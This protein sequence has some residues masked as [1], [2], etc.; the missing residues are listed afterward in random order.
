M[1]RLAK[2][3]SLVLCLFC[4][5]SARAQSDLFPFVVP[6]DGAPS[7]AAD[8]SVLLH[9]PAG[10][11]G[12]VR[13]GADGHFYVGAQRIRFWGVNMTAGSCFQHKQNAP[14]VALRLAKAGVNIVRFHHMDAPWANPSL[15]NYSTGGSRQLNLQALD[16]LDY[17]FAQLKQVGIYTNINL[18]VHRRFS[19]RD[20]LPAEIDSV[21]DMKD[22]HVIGF[23]YQPMIELQKEYARQLLTHRNPYTGLTYA[24]DPAVAFVEINNENGLI[25]GFLGSVLDRIPAVFQQ[26]LQR[27][28][29]E[30]L[31]AK[32]GNSTNLRQAWGERS[33]PLGPEM[34]TNGNYTNGTTGWYLEQHAGAQASATV[35]TDAP[36]GY[37]RSVRIQVTRA[38]SQGWHIQWGQPGLRVVGNGIYTL[39]FWA[40]A[41][42]N[43]NFTVAIAMAHEPWSGLT[44]WTPVSLTTTWRRYEFTFVVRQDDDNA[45]VLF[46]DMGLNTGSYWITGV[47]LRR[48]GTVRVIPVDQSLEARNIASVLRS[49]WWNTPE[50]IQ[51]DWLRFLRDTEERYWNGLYR[52]LK[53]DLGVRALVTGTII[54]CALPSTMAQTDLIDTHSYWQHPE[55][56]GGDWDP[57][58]WFI[59]NIPMVNYR[60]NTF[61]GLAPKRVWGKPFTLSEYNHPAPNTYTSEGLILLAAYALLQDWDAVYFY[62]YAHRRDELDARRITGFFD[63]DQH[64][65]Q[66]MSLVAAAAMFLR[67]DVAP[68]QQLVG[69]TLSREQEIEHL[70][71][72]WAWRLV[73]GEHVGLRGLIALK[74]RVAVALEGQTLPISTLRPD[75]VDTSG[76]VLVSDTG[77]LRWDWSVPGRGVFTVASPRT[78]AVVGFGAGRRFDLGDG[79]VVEPGN[80]RQNGFSAITLTVKQGVLSSQVTQHTQLLITATGYVQNTDWGWEE[81]GDNRVTV[82]D[83]WGRAP[84]LVEGISARIT[85]PMPASVVQVYALDGRGGRT[86]RVPVGRTADGKAVVEIGPQYGTL[87]YE[88]VASARRPITRE[89]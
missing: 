42:T 32:Y 38:G 39:S 40:K 22:Q 64:P 83:N 86:V 43:R 72:S 25:Q 82:R 28:W 65:T 60:D 57:R 80:T 27:Q 53:Q 2:I 81:L 3:L 54:G 12:P 21:T 19:S 37:S 59:R 63:I 41:S 62:T 30:W 15:I 24:Q 36:S 16:N 66:W 35:V 46:T 23:F 48:G 77:Q 73:D 6:W 7:G 33:E 51:K 20:G 69:V 79:V 56:P 50:P 18:L 52:Y 84:S 49:N 5:Q 89:R 29:N 45:R 70:R 55:F 68:A 34:L 74:H 14:K 85:L 17:F 71:W 4:L 31:L 61:T 75:Q 11:F 44:P 26:D 9:R 47:S 8:M 78:K 88:V 76:D 1:K 58:N 10:K 87:W 67:G 13:V